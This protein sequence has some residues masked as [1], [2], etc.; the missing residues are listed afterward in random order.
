MTDVLAHPQLAARD[1]WRDVS[2]PVGTIRAL[3]SALE[4][5]GEVALGP[6]PALGSHTDAVLSE[7][8]Y[9]DGQIAVL[10][11]TGAVA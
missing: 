6:V 10:R 3:R 9:D 4:P 1:R 11:D 8:G 7:L 5:T 2:T